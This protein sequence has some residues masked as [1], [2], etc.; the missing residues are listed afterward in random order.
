M[1]YLGVDQGHSTEYKTALSLLERGCWTEVWVKQN[2]KRLFYLS[3][4]H[5]KFDLNF[6]CKENKYLVT[7]GHFVVKYSCEILVC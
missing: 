3:L 5:I 7:W 2:G 6:C 1:D 4:R